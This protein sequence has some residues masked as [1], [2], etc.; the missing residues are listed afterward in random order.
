MKRKPQT[1]YNVLHIFVGLLLGFML[2]GSMIYWHTNRQTDRILN[3]TFDRVMALF[4]AHT[5]H[6]E[7][8][9]SIIL[10]RENIVPQDIIIQKTKNTTSP[11]NR[12]NQYRI[13]QDKLLYTKILSLPKPVSLDSI[14]NRRLDSLM[15]NTSKNSVDQVYFIEFWES[16]LNFIGYKMGKNKIILYGIKSFELA[17]LAQYEGKTYLR[18]LNEYY[19]LELTTTFKPLVPVNESFFTQDIQPF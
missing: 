18:Y 6:L 9:D 2:G 11:N 4:S 15:G 5:I 1:E 17:S 8:G 3:E 7:T 13:A 14:S 19:P 16:P 10:L 12:N